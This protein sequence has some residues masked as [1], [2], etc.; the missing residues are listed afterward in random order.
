MNEDKKI[1]ELF[2]EDETALIKESL[3]DMFEEI[4]NLPERIA[5]VS[6]TGAGDM[7]DDWN[8]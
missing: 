5:M 6:E 8:D 7:I 2:D 1:I 4:R 3:G